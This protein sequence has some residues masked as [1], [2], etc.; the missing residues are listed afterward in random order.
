MSKAQIPSQMFTYILTLLVIGMM[1]FLGVKWLGSLMDKSEDISMA[2]TKVEME[3]AFEKI[4]T[5]FGSWEYKEFRIPSEATRVCFLDRNYAKNGDYKSTG[6]CTEGNSDYNP[7]ICEAWGAE[8]QSI[9]F[10]PM[11]AMEM[12][13]DV[14]YVEVEGGYIC[15]KN[16]NGVIRVKLTGKGNAVKVSE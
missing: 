11:D 2:K 3:S 5:N 12:T 1:L 4:K 9:V 13:V 8:T 16:E 10:E 6:I 7:I 15:F 14:N